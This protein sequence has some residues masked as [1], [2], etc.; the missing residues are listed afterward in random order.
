M[1]PPL[2]TSILSTTQETPDIKTFHFPHKGLMKPG[3]F[4][5]IWIPNIDEIPMSVSYIK[6]DVKA[7]TFR[8]VGD[9]TTALF[10]KKRDNL[11][12]I[13]GPFGNGFQLHAKRPL[14]IGGGTGIAMLSPAIEQDLRCN[15]EVTVIIGGKTKKE[16]LFKER[17][18]NMS[19]TVHISTDDGSAGHHGYASSLAVDLIA[20]EDFDGIYTCGPELM[21]KTLYDHRNGIPFQAS[22]ERYMKCGIGL[23]GQCSVGKGLRVCFEG[24][25]FDDKT[26]E[27]IKDF[28]IFTRDATGARISLQ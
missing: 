9:A 10:N 26:L 3:Q 17:I 13:R 4:F 16:L 6:P 18:E 25:V 8:K 14:Y 12:G 21:M 2:M 11:I 7:I 15:K 24:P 28:G 20:S 19:A 23:C 27:S 5:M 1:N 22:L